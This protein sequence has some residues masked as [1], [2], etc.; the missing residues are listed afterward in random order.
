M[1]ALS[2]CTS[3]R[4]F[5]SWLVGIAVLWV[6]LWAQLLVVHG[7]DGVDLALGLFAVAC[8]LTVLYGMRSYRERRTPRADRPPPRA[9]TSAAA[10][11]S[12]LGAITWTP[13]LVLVSFS[14]LA[15]HSVAPAAVVL[16]YGSFVTVIVFLAGIVLQMALIGAGQLIAALVMRGHTPAL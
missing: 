6:A 2:P 14:S 10:G 9:F 4:P 15:W 12:L 8:V 7:A 1:L 13:L 16:F 5:R 11:T 3:G